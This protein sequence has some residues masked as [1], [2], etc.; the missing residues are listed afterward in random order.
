M[1]SKSLIVLVIL[2]AGGLG[3]YLFSSKKPV[4]TPIPLPSVTPVPTIGEIVSPTT[5][6]DTKSAIQEILAEK[7]KRPISEVNVTVGKEQPGYAAGSVLFGNGGPSEG[8]M[9]LAVSGNGWQVVWDGNGNVDCNK[10][11]QEYGFP[12]TILKPDFCN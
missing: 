5:Y 9:W 10:M 6:P 4:N 8:G 7:Y 1:K 12:D 11:R 2:V 3:Y